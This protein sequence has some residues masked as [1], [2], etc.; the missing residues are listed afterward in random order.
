MPNLIEAKQGQA[1]NDDPERDGERRLAVYTQHVDGDSDGCRC[2][3][4]GDGLARALVL[5][6][7][8]MYYA[9]AA[10]QLQLRPHH[11]PVG[12]ARSSRLPAAAY[13]L[14]PKVYNPA[15]QILS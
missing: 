3:M 13:F 12:V 1:N 7:C 14:R 15:F 2:N 9:R 6:F 11:N 4:T 8:R 10:C 5:S